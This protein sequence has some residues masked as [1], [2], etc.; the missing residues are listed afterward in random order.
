MVCILPGIVLAQEGSGQSEIGMEVQEAG[1]FVVHQDTGRLKIISTGRFYKN[2]DDLP[3]KVYVISH[4]EIQRK[5]YNTLTDVLNSLPGMRTSQ[6]GSGELG[7]TFQAWGFTGNL[8]TKILLNGVPVK[9][10]G[11]TGMPIGSQLPI[12]QADKI[13]VVYGNSS[14]VYGADAVTGV[15]NII[16]KEPEQDI[17]VRGDVSLGQGNYHYTNFFIGGKGGKNNNILDFSFYGSIAG[18]GDIN[19]KEGY[20]EAYN[21][22]NYYQYRGE[23]V[24]INGVEYAPENITEEFITGAGS[25]V[26]EFID[27]NYG[28]GYEGTLTLPEMENMGSSSHM[29]GL[30]LS[31]KGI[32]FSYNNMYRKTHSSIGL[33]PVFY[34]YNNPQNHWGEVIQRAMLSYNRD[35]KHF[36]S[37]TQLSFLSYAMDNQSSQGVTFYENIDKLYRYSASNDLFFEQTFSASPAKNLEIIGGFSYNQSGALPATNFLRSPFDRADYNLFRVEVD[38]DTLSDDFGFNPTTYN[39][40][41]GFLQSYYR[42]GKFRMLGGVRYDNNSRYGQAVS[43]QIAIMHKTSERTS[44]RLSLGRAYKEPALSLAYQSLAYPNGNLIHY[45]AVPTDMALPNEQLKPEL[46]STL[47]FGLKTTL[48]RRLI[49]DQTYF[50][51]RIT[52]HIVPREFATAPLDLPRPA[53]D[54]VQAWINNQDAV[55]NV[56]G[57]MT[58]LRMN[59][60]I[61]SI[62]LDAEVNLIFQERQDKIP[63]VGEIV[64]EQF[65]LT[66]RHSGNMK[67]TMEPVSRLYV[68]IESHWMT[69]WL[70]IL[71]PVDEWYNELFAETDGYYS[72][73]LLV[74]YGLSHNLDVYMK[75]T[76]LFNEK[77]GSINATFQDESLIYNPQ[78]GRYIRFGLSY[79]LK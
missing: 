65:S 79:R 50:Y 21:P 42:I 33:S 39:N 15:I 78:P 26:E 16:T 75:V 13:E 18:L 70:R 22:L 34:K 47:E 24:S 27:E 7:E 17:F 5:Q 69:K 67:L 20:E 9:P 32:G 1:D 10:S 49:I 66:P 74:S 4:E 36:S 46:F 68:N 71:I 57:I 64:A 3:L 25:T 44:F 38:L 31:F 43:P 51:Y 8:Y 62:K 53:N 45:M 61:A 48:F 2:V 6:P 58:T 55:S 72:M 30:Q 12:R 77:Y 11:V 73:N 29:L 54:S 23:P 56:Y 52:D 19:I 60:I 76:N 37:S 28:P 63:D 14:A 35:F 41:S 40:L 59:D